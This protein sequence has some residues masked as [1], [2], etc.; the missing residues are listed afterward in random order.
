VLPNT[1]TPIKISTEK[2]YSI[3][4]N[5]QLN[6]LATYT[7][8]LTD[9]PTIIKLVKK[10]GALYEIRIPFIVFTVPH[11]DLVLDYCNSVHWLASCFLKIHFIISLS[12]VFSSNHVFYVLMQYGL[13]WD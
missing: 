5:L 4:I 1:P 9:K 8:V 11:V 2:V 10:F 3:A 6:S 12:S 13:V 7:K